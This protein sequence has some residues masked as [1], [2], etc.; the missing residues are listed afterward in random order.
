MWGNINISSHV[1]LCPLLNVL[2]HSIS[3]LGVYTE[4]VISI[5]SLLIVLYSYVLRYREYLI[6]ATGEE[7]GKTL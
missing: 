3:A 7:I 6:A 2:F 5:L 4:C 1:A